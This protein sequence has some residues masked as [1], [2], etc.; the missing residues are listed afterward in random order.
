[1]D[2]NERNGLQEIIDNALAEMAEEGGVAQMS[3]GNGTWAVTADGAT[4]TSEDIT[5]K[6]TVPI[7]AI[8][9]EI[10]LDY[11]GA[12]GGVDFIIAMAKMER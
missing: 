3:A 2:Q 9:D 5:G 8:G 7:L 11:S 12:F 10:A 1:M 4:L 6:H